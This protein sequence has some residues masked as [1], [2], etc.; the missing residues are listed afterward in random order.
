MKEQLTRLGTWL[1][2][3]DLRFPRI[4]RF[5]R[6]FLL[7]FLIALLLAA[8]VCCAADNASVAARLAKKAE[9]ARKSGQLVRAYLLYAEA[10]AR[11]PKNSTYAL[12]RDGLAPL[13]KLLTSASVQ[14]DVTITEDVK[15]AEQ[16]SDDDTPAP[17]DELT[18]AEKAGPELDGLPHLAFEPGLHSFDLRTDSKSEIQQVA[19][20]YGIKTIFDPEFESKPTGRFVLDD[21]DFKTAMQGITAVTET[22][23]FPVDTHTIFVAHDTEMKRDEYEPV[24]AAAIQVPDAVDQKDVMDAANAVRGALGVRFIAWDHETKTIVFRDRVSLVRAATGVLKAVT[25]PRG[26]LSLK[27]EIIVADESRSVHY[28][29]ALPTSFPAFSFAHIGNLQTQFPDLSSATSGL[30]AFASGSNFFGI[31]LGS[32]SAFAT[33]SHSSSSILFEATVLVADGQ[34]A[35]L[36]V[37]DKYP[38]PQTIYTGASQSSLP[39]VYNPIGQVTLEDLGLVLKISPHITGGGQ[40]AM[41][42]EAEYQSLSGLSIDTIPAISQRTFKGSVRLNPNEYAIVA[43]LSDD[44]NTVTKSG[45]PGL[46]QIPGIDQVLAENRRTRTSSNT[47]LLIKPTITRYPISD[48]ISPQFLLG[49]IRGNRVVL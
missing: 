27:V 16:G 6:H 45:I 44:E 37:G 32:A 38:I 3:T 8:A 34:T 33:Y 30:F 23:V 17:F 47:L 28:G 43:G 21:A 41:D 48:S 18:D 19:E 31:A 2:D 1:R 25:I 42:V 12:N 35:S 13:A 14:S 40:V 24:V 36:H 39:G 10:S 26:Q 20:A 22:F 46:A 29:L 4:L 15:Q 7:K 5:K 9:Q 49:S 11:E